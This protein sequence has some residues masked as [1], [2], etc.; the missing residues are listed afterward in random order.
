MEIDSEQIIKYWISE[1]DE[2]LEVAEHLLEKE[3]LSYALFFGHLALEKSLK[4]IYV[5]RK[6]EHAPPIH[7]LHRLAKLAGLKMTDTQ[8]ECLLLVTSF[9]IEA[10]YPDIKRAFRKKCTK[11]YTQ[12]QMVN[13]RELFSWLK[14]MMK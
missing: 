12:E 2:A 8:I 11:E 10:R 4:A 6:G 1:A 14:K 7:N 13:I 5:Q 3:D 9:N